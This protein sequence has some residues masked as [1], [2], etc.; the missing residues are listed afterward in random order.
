MNQPQIIT[1]SPIV[2]SVL[3]EI[4]TE[5]IEYKLVENS[6]INKYI[7]S[8]KLIILNNSNQEVSSNISNNQL[9]DLE[10]S[11]Q[12][13]TDLEIKSNFLINPFLGVKVVELMTQKVNSVD[14]DQSQTIS[15]NSSKLVQKLQT[16]VD[17]YSQLNSCNLSQINANFEGLEF[18][19]SQ[20]IQVNY[21]NELDLN[22]QTSFDTISTQINSL[23][24][25]EQ[26]NLLY[27]NQKN[28]ANIKSIADEAGI[29]L[30][31]FNVPNDNS[32]IDSLAQIYQQNL[33]SLQS[34]L[35]C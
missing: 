18:L 13:N 32:S 24:Q 3:D 33:T 20:Q 10:A 19:Q 14:L 16:I 23:I 12:K 30:I 4:L 5:G 28:I 29:N 34:A 26:K 7:D 35:E 8:S 11:L 1:N 6:S 27:D 15:Q 25:K 21:I 9:L 17:D 2:G 31:Q 22:D